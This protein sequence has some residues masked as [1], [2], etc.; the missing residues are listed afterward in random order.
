MV[1]LYRIISLLSLTPLF[2]HV[3]TFCPFRMPYLYCYICPLRCI[4]SRIRWVVWI[5][6]IG[7]NII[8][9][10]IFCS[11]VCPFGTAQVLLYKI[12]TKKIQLSYYL[13]SLKYIGIIIITLV[14]IITKNQELLTYKFM[15]L[16]LNWLFVFKMKD[17]V[18]YSFI[19]AIVTSIL[20]YRFFCH[21]LC[22]IRALDIILNR[23]TKKLTIGH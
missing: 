4:W 8:K 23:F 3:F 2:F 11:Y 5:I 18:F 10:N 7:A 15:Q 6:A 19:I 22:P 20:S 17:L 21:C 14:I 9:K 16:S 12:K 13:R 1:E